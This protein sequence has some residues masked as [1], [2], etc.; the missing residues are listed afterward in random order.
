MNVLVVQGKNIKTVVAD[1]SYNMRFQ[2]E[3][4]KEAYNLRCMP[5]FNII[6]G[7]LILV[8]LVEEIWSDLNILKGNV[9]ETRV[10][11]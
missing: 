6:K 5:L 7:V 11:L 10:S 4:K 2:L 9:E 8:I 3:V 1:N